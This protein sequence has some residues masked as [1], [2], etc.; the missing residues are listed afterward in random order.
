MEKAKTPPGGARSV[1]VVSS[2]PKSGEYFGDI[3]SPEDFDPVMFAGSAGEAKRLLV[4]TSADIA[5]I[6]APLSDEFG[7]ELATA[8]S[9]LPMGVILLVKSSVYDEIC[10]RVESCGVLTV[11]KPCARQTL[12]MTLRLAVATSAR[13]SRMEKKNRSLREKVTDIKIVNHAK[14]LLITELGMSEEDAHRHI[15][16][17]A[18][19]TRLSLREVSENIIRTYDK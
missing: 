17:Q 9:D 8:L 11:P 7:S 1:L 4:S 12:Y 6:N 10:C 13:L 3:L 18:M 19:N 2:S 16:K 5:I 15:E 14:W